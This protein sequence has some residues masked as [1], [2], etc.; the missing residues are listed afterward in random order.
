MA[1]KR[2]DTYA[3]VEISEAN[4]HF[5]AYLQE[6]IVVPDLILA[7]FYALLLRRFGKQTAQYWQRKIEPY[8]KSVALPILIEA[9]EFRE[10][11][12]KENISFF[13]AVGYTYS[14]KNNCLFVTGDREF[15]NLKN[16]EFRK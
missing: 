14:L 3:L 1:L 2:L 16:V 12:R 11:H 7:E 15:K 13:D 8:A 10:G 9:M 4:P 5:S 6:D